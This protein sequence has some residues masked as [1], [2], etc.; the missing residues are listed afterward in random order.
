MKMK[1]PDSNLENFDRELDDLFA[2]YLQACPA[3]EPSPDFMPRIWQQIEAR[4]SA[5]SAFGRWTRAFVT[6]AA[7]IC[8][9]LGLMQT[10]VP[11]QPSFYTQTYLESL[12]DENS[13][14]TPTIVEALYVDDGGASY[15]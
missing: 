8:I 14:E 7:A 5:S 9:L 2:A 11:S 1:P 12:Q 13:T 3:P 6:A 15:Q 4:R 10:Y